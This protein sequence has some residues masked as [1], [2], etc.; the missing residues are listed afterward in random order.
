MAYGLLNDSKMVTAYFSMNE[1]EKNEVLQNVKTLILD[2]IGQ[3]IIF[4]HIHL[5]G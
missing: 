4:L 3:M 2:F 1:G 5:N